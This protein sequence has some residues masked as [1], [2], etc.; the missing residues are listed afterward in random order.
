[1]ACSHYSGVRQLDLSRG[2]FRFLLLRLFYRNRGLNRSTV[3]FVIDP[4]IIL[5]KRTACGQVFRLQFLDDRPRFPDSNFVSLLHASQQKQPAAYQINPAGH[6][7]TEFIYQREDGLAD[8]R[9]TGPSN[10][11][12]TMPNIGLSFAAFQRFQMAGRKN[13]LVHRLHRRAQYKVTQFRLS[14]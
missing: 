1:M 11:L 8:L 2:S 6:T 4:K 7:L 12:E 9:I 10:P 5:C 14:Q 3:I 13:A